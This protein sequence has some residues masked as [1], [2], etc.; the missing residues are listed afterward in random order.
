MGPSR[1]YQLSL[2]TQGPTY[3]PSEV[4]DANGDFVVIGRINR[5]DGAGGVSN[6]W[7]CAIVSAESPLPPFGGNEPYRI[8]R[9]LPDHPGQFSPAD[10]EIVLY[11]LPLP[12]PCSNYPMVFAPEQFPKAS[13][14]VRPSYPFH[15]VDVPDLRAQDGP[16][17]TEPVT[18][19]T[20]GRAR[21]EL[22]VRLAGD[23]KSAEFSF[24]FAGMLPNSLYTVMSLR[25]RD[26]DPA[27]PTRPGPLGVPNAF[28]TDQDGKGRY[29]AS[30]P[31]PFPAPGTGGNRIV[32]VIVL[33]MSYQQNYGGAIGQFGLGGDIHAQLKLQGP[34]FEEFTT[35]G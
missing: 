13:E 1:T 26:L 6:G 11:T 33:W 29:R 15:Q 22:E 14:V 27:G 3:P 31:D 35:T 23:A 21:G 19:G 10:N 12:L 7:G 32:N 4:M 24:E 28:V 30:L 9:D 34:S 8:V 5:D 25:A 17:V 2:T 18:L 20:W 16:K